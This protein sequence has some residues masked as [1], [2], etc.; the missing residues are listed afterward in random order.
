MQPHSTGRLYLNFPGLGEGETLV[1]EAFGK[2]TYKRLQEIKRH[3]DPQN[4]FL[5]NQNIVPA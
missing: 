3:Y 5:M 1:A 4:V 2:A